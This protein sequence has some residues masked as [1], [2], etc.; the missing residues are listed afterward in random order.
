MRGLDISPSA[1]KWVPPNCILEVEDITKEWIWTE[2]F[3]L[4]HIKQLYEALTAEETRVMYQRIYD[5]LEPGGWIEQVEFDPHVLSMNNHMPSTA[6]FATWDD[7]FID[8]CRRA[9]TLSI[10][11][12]QCGMIWLMQGYRIFMRLNVSAR[13]NRGRRRRFIRMRSIGRC[14]R[15]RRGLRV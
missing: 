9:I 10:L 14:L 12:T 2:R 3:D 5:N 4:N 15:V 6:R 1:V 8:V 7:M 13:L 11:S